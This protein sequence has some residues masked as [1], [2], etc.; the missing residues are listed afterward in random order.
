MKEIKINLL[1]TLLMCF[2]L[3]SCMEVESFKHRQACLKATEELKVRHKEDRNDLRIE[4][5]RGDLTKENYQQILEDWKTMEE[6][7]AES[8][9]WMK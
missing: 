8:C 6:A 5:L 7:K 3:T 4:W 9:A 1:G 2:L